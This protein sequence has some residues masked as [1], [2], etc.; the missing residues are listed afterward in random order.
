MLVFRAKFLF[1]FL[2]INTR[3]CAWHEPIIQAMLPFYIADIALTI[4]NYGYHYTIKISWKKIS[5]VIKIRIVWL[6]QY[7]QRTQIC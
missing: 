1:R 2:I 6:K 4:T 7:K 5:L 3:E